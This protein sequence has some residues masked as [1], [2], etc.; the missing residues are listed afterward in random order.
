MPLLHFPGIVVQMSTANATVNENA[1]YID[2]CTELTTGILCIETSITVES[3]N[4]L[5]IG[6]EI[7]SMT[8]LTCIF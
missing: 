4:G 5:A 2:V 8:I 7:T 1:G 3:E 6:E